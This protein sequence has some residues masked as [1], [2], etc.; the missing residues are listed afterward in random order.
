VEPELKRMSFDQ[1]D[2]HPN[3]VFTKVEATFKDGVSTTIKK[4]K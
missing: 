4:G 1:N 3:E 2:S